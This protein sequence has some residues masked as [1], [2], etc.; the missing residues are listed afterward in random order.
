MNKNVQR[1]LKRL[2]SKVNKIT[3]PVGKG[4]GK[5][6]LKLYESRK[7]SQF[8]GAEKIIDELR[9]NNSIAINKANLLIDKYEKEQ[10]ITKRIREKRNMKVRKT[11]YVS[12]Q[13]I[14]QQRKERT[15]K[16]GVVKEDV[17]SADKA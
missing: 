7:I 17:I 16:N 2:S 10:P 15:L 3:N 4:L 5:E 6:V 11:F 9:K 13:W 12:G 14:V 1:N 8:H